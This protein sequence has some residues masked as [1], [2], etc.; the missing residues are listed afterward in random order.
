M[1]SPV[2]PVAPAAPANR[3]G[4]ARIWRWRAAAAGCL[5]CLATALSP[6]PT[7]LAAAANPAAG[8]AHAGAARAT[9]A[10]ATARLGSP[11]FG[12]A[13][14]PRLVKDLLAAWQITRGQGVTLAIIGQGVD[15]TATGLAGRV[16]A[17]PSFG[18][19]AHD[20]V[21]PDTVFASAVAGA[22]P[23]PRNPSGTIGL[24][25]QA[26]ILSLRVPVRST[27][28]QSDDARAIRYAARHGARVIFVDV[29]GEE[30]DTSLDSAVQYAESR[31][32]VVIGD[33]SFRRGRP[34]AAEYPT[35]LPGVLGARAVLLP[36]LVTPPRPVMS[37][38]NDSVLVAA[39]GDEL[40]VTG[41]AGAGYTIF[42]FFA[43]EAWLTAT[44]TLIKAVY[45]GLPAG[46]VARA[47]AVSARDHPRRGYSTQLGFG[48]INPAGALHAAAALIKLPV[49]VAPGPG[50]VAP[51]A[52]LA[53][54]AAPGVVDA[55]H[56]PLAKLA[57]CAAAMAAGL[58]LL[59]L[60]VRL[61]RRR[62]RGHRRRHASGWPQG[63][64]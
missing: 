53:A 31:H 4:A 64:S 52:R 41:P 19:V 7:A 8:A 44:V 61:P 10:S 30:D 27:V 46:L 17:G 55:V 57:G 49:R 13:A 25:P 12:P 24:A 15:R 11:L 50:V 39:P 16:I 1:L 6:G 14:A 37:P 45:P 2:A 35:S 28:W 29:V 5:G 51:Q 22:G 32:A 56:H 47:I 62:R 42:N 43:A 26:R 59:G 48:L 23:S 20:S 54:G 21:A 9:S 18:N 60:A 36:G 34:N 58:I 38:A 63:A 40:N 33:E 3:A